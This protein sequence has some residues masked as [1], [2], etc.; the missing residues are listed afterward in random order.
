MPEYTQEQLTPAYQALCKF[1]EEGHTG[2]IV[3]G[4]FKGAC[5]RYV[6]HAAKSVANGS[7]PDDEEYRQLYRVYQEAKQFAEITEV[8]T[9]LP[10]DRDFVEGL[11]G[12]VVKLCVENRRR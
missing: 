4:K 1:S 9:V 11:A 5:S 12:L 2:L 3:L 8:E 7:K 10:D 6:G